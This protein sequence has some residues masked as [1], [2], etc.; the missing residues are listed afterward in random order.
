VFHQPGDAVIGTIDIESEI[1][2][3]FGVDVQALLE[4]C[5]DLIRPLWKL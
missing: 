5:S 2:N 1:P 4:I 3:A